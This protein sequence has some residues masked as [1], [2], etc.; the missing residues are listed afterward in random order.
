MTTPG[1][2]PAISFNAW[3]TGAESLERFRASMQYND[4]MLF[5]KKKRLTE[6]VDCAG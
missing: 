6:M 2:R 5:R 1:R 3:K 4:P